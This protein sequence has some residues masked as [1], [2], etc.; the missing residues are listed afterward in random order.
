MNPLMVA[1]AATNVA[2]SI[3]GI[4]QGS[5]M[6]KEAKKIKP[7]WDNSQLRDRLGASQMQLNARN[8]YAEAQRRNVLG[9]QANAMAQ[10]NR[11]T[12]DP[13]QALAIAAG[14]QAQ[15]DQ[16]LF[17]QNAQEQQGA[18][19]RQQMLREDQ[20]AMYQDMGNKFQ[21]DQ[22]RKDALQSAGRQTIS[23]A[24]SH[25]SSGLMAAGQAGI[26]NNWFA[27]KGLK[28]G[29]DIPTDNADLMRATAMPKKTS[30]PFALSSS[31]G[32]VVTTPVLTYDR[33]AS[34]VPSFFTNQPFKKY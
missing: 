25:M 4:I 29:A 32:S 23:N 11:G 7:V 12:V 14:L 18:L 5:K 17:A 15:T 21:I 8:P 16:S 3:F 19:Q 1:G 10:V 24:F 9:S 31:I 33:I 22:E 2:N 13:S 34:A 26:G 6:L 28:A 30:N 27:G 20:A